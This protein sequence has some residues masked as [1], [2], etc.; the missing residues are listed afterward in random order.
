MRR[1]MPGGSGLTLFQGSHP[2]LSQLD[3]DESS[4]ATAKVRGEEGSKQG[5]QEGVSRRT[6]Q[7]LNRP[8]AVPLRRLPRPLGPLPKLPAGSPSLYKEN[9]PEE[10]KQHPPQVAAAAAALK[11]RYARSRAGWF[12]KERSTPEGINMEE[13]GW[14]FEQ[15]L[16]TPKYD[17]ESSS[18]SDW[19]TPVVLRERKPLE[20]RN[21]RRQIKLALRQKAARRHAEVALRKYNRTNNTKFE[22]VEVKVISIFFECGAG[23]IHY[24]F[25]A[26]QPEDHNPADDAGV[27]KLFFSELDH[28]CR[29]EDDV[30]LCCIVGENDARHCH[31]CEDYQPVVH[32][33][34]QAY[35]GGSTTFIDLPCSDGDSTDSD[36]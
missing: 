4:A 32:P 30:M 18:D 34:S 11:G 6:L 5:E 13:H 36:Y 17:H 7:I 29:N 2:C 26:K 3:L 25:T 10:T 28:R 21:A 15:R 24:N 27:P 22:L 14:R 12:S 19:D 20:V 8:I 1:M 23:C 33:S 31:G 35:G 16:P 9:L